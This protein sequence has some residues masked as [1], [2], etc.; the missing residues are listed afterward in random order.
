MA[1]EA[2]ATSRFRQFFL[3]G[4]GIL[5]PTVLTIWILMAVFQFVDSRIADPINRGVQELVL[6]TPWPAV[7]SE[8]MMHV[9]QA[10]TP[11]QRSAWR[12][13][14]STQ[15]WL[16]HEARR[17]ELMRVWNSIALGPWVLTNLIGLLIAVVLIYV[18]GAVLGSMLGRGMYQR[19]ERRFRRLPVVKAV[20]PYVKQVTDFLF[21]DEKQFQFNRV[22]AVQYPRKGLWSVGLV[23]GD[24]MRMIQDIAGQECITVFIPSS[25]TPFTGYVITVPV[26][27]TIELNISIDDALRFVISGGVIVPESQLIVRPDRS[28]EA[29]AAATAAPGVPK[30]GE[31]R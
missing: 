5:L 18:V 30:E 14:G 3:R 29:D 15:A 27:D 2:Q 16:V 4:L 10:L 7:S 1:R 23:T 11:E 20:Y 28:I 21:S 12:A 24:T 8:E 13:A 25:P 26:A 17:I 19:M 9:E 31:I 6:L 22:I